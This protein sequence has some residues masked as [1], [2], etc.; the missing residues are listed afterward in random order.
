MRC[1]DP[2]STGSQSCV[3]V[4]LRS[5]LTLS[6]RPLP[7]CYRE[8]C[9]PPHLVFARLPHNSARVPHG[10]RNRDVRRSVLLHLVT[11]AEVPPTAAL[12]HILAGIYSPIKEKLK[13]SFFAP[14]WQSP[15]RQRHPHPHLSGLPPRR[16]SSRTLLRH[17]KLR[18]P[19]LKNNRSPLR[20]LT[21]KHQWMPLSRLTRLMHCDPHP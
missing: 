2:L 19:K 6:L 9:G 13:A 15:R 21:Q 20:L 18:L 11:E 8:H 1:R 7:R 16:Q 12:C 14:R 4:A 3:N 5:R 10:R 17:K